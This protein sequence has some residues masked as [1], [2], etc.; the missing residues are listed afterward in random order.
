[1]THQ[2]LSCFAIS[3]LLTQVKNL[4]ERQIHWSLWGTLGNKMDTAAIL[5]NDVKNSLPTFR[6]FSEPWGLFMN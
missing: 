5:V 2:Y 1:M 6:T 4:Q 3:I